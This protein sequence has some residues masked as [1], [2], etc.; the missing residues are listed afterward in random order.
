MIPAVIP[1]LTG[2]SVLVTR[3]AQQSEALAAQIRELGGEAWVLPAIDI[4]PL[5]ASVTAAYQLVIFV[6]VN[7]VDHGASLIVKNADTRIAAIGRATAAALAAASLPADIV[8]EHGFTSEVLLEHP[9][10][11]LADGARILIVRGR[12]G[13]EFLQ[14][15]FTA[16][17]LVVD[18]LD[19]YERVM[20]ALDELRRA[21]L[22]SLWASGSIDAVTVTSVETLNNLAALLS[23]QGR[24]LLKSTPLVV[25]SGRVR[26]AAA[27]MG[28]CG[29]CLVASG[30]DDVSIT[31]ALSRWH[32]RAR[33]PAAPAAR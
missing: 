24:Q 14:Q 28:L 7:A 16:R 10:L 19:V 27:Q 17:G 11:T 18:T 8:P 20:P 22:E 23:E 1:P 5:H 3:P 32:A 29:E 9:Q 21:E 15:T 2:L 25:P 13:R 6:S 31:G 26:D 4:R 33:F 12:G 30:A